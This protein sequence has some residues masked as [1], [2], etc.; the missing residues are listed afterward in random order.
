MGETKKTK[1]DPM[2]STMSLGD[3]LE[4]LRARLILAILGL[5]IGAVVSL[6]FGTHIIKFIERPYVGAMQK[7]VKAESTAVEPNAV[8][9]VDLLFRNLRAQ[10]ATDANAP[11]LDPNQV[12]FLRQVTV[13]TL[14]Q[15]Y[16]QQ[17]P[18][19]AEGLGSLPRHARLQTLAPAEAFS[20]YMKV[21]F[22]AGL[23]LTCPWVFY[24]LWMF[25]AA[26]LYEHERRYVRTAVP[27]SAGLFVGGALFFLFIVAPIS[28]EF[29]LVFGDLLGVA[30]GWTLQRYISF[31]TV[32]MLVFGLAFQTPIA[33]FILNRTGL[34]S[35]AALRRVR[36]YVFLGVFV[37]SAAVTPPDVVSQIMLG[38]PLYALYELG[39]LL[40]QLAG[41]RAAAK[42]QQESSSS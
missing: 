3:H 2:N 40:A 31:V 24:Q 12:E 30:S 39:I 20:A 5:T 32:L 38:F 9:L 27:F 34:V 17:T 36:K 23:I 22:I 37:V 10:S 1:R 6:I 18:L 42:K 4:E 28:L 13:T 19:K 25:V 7:R 11:P 15:W 8:A 33:I 35:L 16:D 41:K 21:S 26:G 14:R 29:F